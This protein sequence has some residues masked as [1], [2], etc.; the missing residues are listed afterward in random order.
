MDKSEYFKQKLDEALATDVDEVQDVENAE[1]PLAPVKPAPTRPAPSRPAREKPSKPERQPF[2]PPRPKRMPEPKN[3]MESENDIMISILAEAYEDEAHPSTQG[4]WKDLPGNKEHLFAKHPVLAMLGDKLSR[5]AW[6][7]VSDRVTNLNANHADGMRVMRQIVQKE[8]EHK[9]ELIALAKK[10]TAQIWGIPEE[11]LEGRITSD[12]EKNEEGGEEKPKPEFDEA[13]RKQINKR[14]TM[15]AMTQGSAV[16]AMM[17]MHH[18]VDKEIEKIDPELLGLYN[19]ISSLSLQ[20]YWMIDIPAMFAML[21][22]AAV[23]STKVNQDD[24]DGGY[25]IDARGVV[26][27]VLAQEMNKGVAELL[28]FHG[29]EDLSA[30]ETEQVLS[31]ADDIEH[32]PYLIQIGPE[33]WRQFLKAKPTGAS[34]ADIITSLAVQEPDHLHKIVTAVVENPEEAS[35]LLNVLSDDEEERD[36]YD[37]GYSDDVD[38]Y[39]E[40]EHDEYDDGYSDDD[41]EEHD[42]DTYSV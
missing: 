20:M 8:S 12:V 10:I 32:E 13:M 33:L 5:D 42:D 9:D 2:N 22:M 1:A 34:L 40:E 41:E 6:G 28:S 25:K 14:L 35:S 30:E 36:E 11:M 16:H 3:C 4:F 15:N 37:D 17:T 27:P 38:E 31:Y 21:G 26:F 19:Q 23:G 29:L 39:D 18:V 7:H 24:D